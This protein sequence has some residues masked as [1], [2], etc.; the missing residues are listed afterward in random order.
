MPD[1]PQGH[2]DGKQR[3][4]EHEHGANEEKQCGEHQAQGH[5]VGAEEAE[6]EGSV[7]LE[8]GGVGRGIDE[9]PRLG[10]DQVAGTGRSGDEERGEAARPARGQ[11]ATLASEA[12]LAGSQVRLSSV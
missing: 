11:V 2:A 12:A 10:E 7:K 5:D 6:D 1:H 4:T 9:E 8:A 3:I